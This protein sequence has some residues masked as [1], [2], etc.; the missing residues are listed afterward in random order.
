MG[1]EKRRQVLERECVLN[2]KVR[3]ETSLPTN[4]TTSDESAPVSL[5]IVLGR[6]SD[7]STEEN[8]PKLTRLTL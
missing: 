8:S 1:R 2:R 6:E 4:I 3:R 5:G 7:S